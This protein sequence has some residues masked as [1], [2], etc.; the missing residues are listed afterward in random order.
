VANVIPC[1]YAIAA[2]CASSTV[3]G[4][5]ARLES[6][7]I[8]AYWAVQSQSSGR[9]RP[10]NSAKITSAAWSSASLRFPSG[11]RAMPASI[12]AFAIAGTKS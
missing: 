7:K 6:A 12:S 1:R 9:Q 11:K 2:I 10:E 5:P 4:R 8:L 3:I